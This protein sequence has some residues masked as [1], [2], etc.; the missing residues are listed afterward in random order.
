MYASVSYRAGGSSSGRTPAFGAGYLGSIPSPPAIFPQDVNNPRHLCSRIA[1]RLDV[2]HRVRLASAVIRRSRR[3]AHLV[4]LVYLVSLG[5][6]P[7]TPL[8]PYVSPFTPLALRSRTSR[9]REQATECASLR[10]L[11]WHPV[12]GGPSGNLLEFLQSRL[13]QP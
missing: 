4:H 12:H 3:S 9:S 5:E 11:S 1:Q 2:R 6:R 7:A 13:C 10:R 8:T